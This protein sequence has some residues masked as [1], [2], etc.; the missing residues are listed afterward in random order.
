MSETAETAET[1]EAI[2][3]L[4][5]D[6]IR[7]R[8]RQFCKEYEPAYPVINFHGK[9]HFYLFHHGHCGVPFVNSDVCRTGVKDEF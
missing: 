3:G 4:T 9:C 7:V 6:E 5:I 8:G 2:P 1:A